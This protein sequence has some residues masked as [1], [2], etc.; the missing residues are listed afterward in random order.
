MELKEVHTL[1]EEN[2]REEG[3]SVYKYYFFKVA[4]IKFQCVQNFEKIFNSTIFFEPLEYD[5]GLTN[6]SPF[7]GSTCILLEFVLVVSC[8]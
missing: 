3:Q 5:E 8:E 2:M 6:I 7:F 4:D 1:K